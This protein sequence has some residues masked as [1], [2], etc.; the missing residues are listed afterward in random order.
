MRDVSRLYGDADNSP[1]ARYN[2]SLTLSFS[3]VG[4]SVNAIITSNRMDHGHKRANGREVLGGKCVI[5]SQSMAIDKKGMCVCD[6]DLEH[7]LS[8]REKCQSFCNCQRAGVFMCV[9]LT[10]KHVSTCAEEAAM[11]PH[12]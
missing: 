8:E 5:T 10:L 1:H 3:V 2:H 7:Q 9:Y 12:Q 11:S 6:D 4:R